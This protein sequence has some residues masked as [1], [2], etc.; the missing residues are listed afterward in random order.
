[1]E[2]LP[3]SRMNNDLDHAGRKTEVEVFDPVQRK[4]PFI[5][6]RYSYREVSS[7][8]GNTYVKAK[9]KSFENG[10]FKSE[11][12]EGVAPGNIHGNMAAEM[13]KM[14][15]GQIVSVVKAFTTFLPGVRKR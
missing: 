3:V 7:V 9:E 4:S 11:E 8:G 5:S 13:Q 15:F 10:K 2:K 14:V 6:F 12:F 1:M